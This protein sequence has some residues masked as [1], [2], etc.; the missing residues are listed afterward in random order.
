MKIFLLSPIYASTTDSYG[1]TPIVHYFAKEWVKLGHQI[2][3]FN[4][5]AKYPKPLYW[6]SKRYQHKLNTRLGMLIPVESP[7]DGDY[8]T[9]GVK[10]IRRGITK[11]IPHGRYSNKSLN[12]AIKIIENEIKL[13]GLPDLFIG[14]WDSPQLD[15]LYILKKIYNIPTCLVFHNI[16]FNLDKKYGKNTYKMLDSLDVIG[17]RNKKALG[18][19]SS[20]YGKPKKYFIAASGVSSEFLFEGG[21]IQRN[22]ENGIHNFIFVGSLIERKYPI[23]I[24]KALCKVYPKG[25]FKI[26]YVGDGAEKKSIE[27]FHAENG[28]KGVIEFTGRIPREKI[29]EYLKTADVFVM[30]SKNEVFGLVYLEAM[31][32]GLITIGSKKEGI[33]GIIKDGENGFLCEAGNF[34]ELEKLIRKISNKNSSELKLI[35]KKAYETSLKFSD[36]AVAKSYIESLKIKHK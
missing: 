3:V 27:K 23:A 18:Q 26:T 29:I 19:Y 17:F 34:I 20:I 13:Q 36:A 8:Y 10:V 28:K 7:K 12:K 9:E 25:N 32:L 22:Y 15:L 4:F 30:I 16:D 1:T 2:T 5:V 35:S 31:A 11:F 21:L 33:D 14:H 6:I 24:L